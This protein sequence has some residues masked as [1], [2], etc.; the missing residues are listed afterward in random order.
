GGQHLA[1]RLRSTALSC[2]LVQADEV[3]TSCQRPQ[4]LVVS[5]PLLQRCHARFADALALVGFAPGWE[6]SYTSPDLVLY[7]LPCHETRC[8]YQPLDLACQPLQLAAGAVAVP[9][10]ARQLEPV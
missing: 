10:E 1:A 3:T 9:G 4:V 8:F 7:R 6:R 5:Q 2:Q